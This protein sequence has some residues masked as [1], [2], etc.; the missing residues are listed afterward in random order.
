MMFAMAAVIAMAVPG[1]KDLKDCTRTLQ[2]PCLF[3]STD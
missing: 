1:L 3:G 2:E